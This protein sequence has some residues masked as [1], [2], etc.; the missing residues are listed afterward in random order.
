MRTHVP[1]ARFLQHRFG[2]SFAQKRILLLKNRFAPLGAV[3]AVLLLAGL[4]LLAFPSGFAQTPAP[5]RSSSSS[6]TGTTTAAPGSAPIRVRETARQLNPNRLPNY[7]NRW[8]IYGGLLFMNG[9]AGQNLPKRYNMGGGELMG[10][11][12]LGRRLGVSGDYRLGAGT[13]DLLPTA[14]LANTRALVFQNIVSGGVS[15]R[16]PKNRYAA[17][18]FHALAGATHGQFDHSIKNDA[19]LNPNTPPTAFGLYNNST[20]PW[21]AIGGSIDFNAVPR[22]AVR[23]SP[24]MTF[25]HFGTETR[26]FFSISLGVVYR[27]GHR[28]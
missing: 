8:E 9:Q 21:G 25:E 7:N 6:Q 12:W 28:R 17:I 11:Y 19:N 5:G 2:R 4:P 13:S 14:P 20:S 22:V 1:C 10:T 18:D 15:V 16:G 23:L 24:D 3:R 27:F 26:E